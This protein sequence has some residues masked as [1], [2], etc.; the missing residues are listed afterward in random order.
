MSQHDLKAIGIGTPGVVDPATQA[1]KMAAR[2]DG[3]EGIRLEQALR[4]WFECQIRVDNDVNLALLGEQW[5]GAAKDASNVVFVNL[6]I[7]IGAAI[8]IDGR[9]YHGAHGAAGEVGYLPLPDPLQMGAPATRVGALEQAAGGL[10]IARRGRAAA[11]RPDGALLRRLA[12]DDVDAIDARLVFEAAR[13]GD[14]AATSIVDDVVRTLA[15]GVAAI[16]A[17]LNPT[18]VVVGGGLSNAGDLL[19]QAIGSQL[20]QL[21]P[22]APTVVVSSLGDQAV[23]LGA[24][25]LALGA[26]LHAVEQEFLALSVRDGVS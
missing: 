12:G 2:I 1:V 26:A 3:W 13:R 11:Q 10:A 16:C 25:R 15:R 24:V 17:V 6:G 8:V 9:L 20:E 19:V 21:V 4:P 7:G 22:F 18:L 14:P 23:P 5:L